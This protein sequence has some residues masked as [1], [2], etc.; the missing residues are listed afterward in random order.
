MSCNKIFCYVPITNLEHL[1]YEMLSDKYFKNKYMLYKY[2][3]R[4]LILTRN[5]LNIECV[6]RSITKVRY[7]TMC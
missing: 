4:G 3:S 6:N 2:I 7:I 5:L 1:C